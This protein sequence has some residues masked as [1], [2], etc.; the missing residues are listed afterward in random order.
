MKQKNII[1]L[2][3]LVI[4]LLLLSLILVVFIKN[5]NSDSRKFA[6]EYKNV[7]RK[8]VYTYA[9]IEKIITILD[10]GTG[11]IYLCNPSSYNCKEYSKALNYIAKALDIE[12]INYYNTSK[13]SDKSEE[14][15]EL[16]V[17]LNDKIEYDTSNYKLTIPFLIIVKD[18][19]I[20]GIDNS[21]STE[22][23]Q[24]DNEIKIE[25]EKE[26]EK[27]IENIMIDSG[28]T[29]CTDECQ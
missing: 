25:N 4:A 14:Y 5:L 27:Q 8:N 23:D 20:I 24:I 28:I 16:L 7:S 15:N 21:Y 26:L 29:S 6:K 9:N 13:F 1:K 18:G 10:D 11:I 19:K 22:Y 17:K 3:I 2:M 12:K